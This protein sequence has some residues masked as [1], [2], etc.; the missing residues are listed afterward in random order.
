MFAD[1]ADFDRP[2]GVGCGD[3]ARARHRQRTN[4]ACCDGHVETLTLEE[5]GYTLNPDGSVAADGPEATNARFSANNRD[6][7]PPRLNR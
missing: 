5:L 1:I 4:A 7:D 3:E 2:R 6:E